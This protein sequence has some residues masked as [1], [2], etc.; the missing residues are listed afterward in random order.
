M[1]KE[2]EQSSDFDF[3][4]HLRNTILL[5]GGKKEIADLLV[6]SQD[7]NV[8]EGDVD[9]L[10]RYNIAL[11]EQNKERFVNLNNIEIR[12]CESE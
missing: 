9:Q 12:A 7:F 4:H 8:T 1:E 6:K 11:I 2:I 3:R 5:L 10:R